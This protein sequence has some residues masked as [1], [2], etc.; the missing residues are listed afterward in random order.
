MQAAISAGDSQMTK[1]HFIELA[2]AISAIMDEHAR[3]QAASAVAGVA[4]QM[5]PRFDT[6]RFFAACGVVQ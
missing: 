5:N 6:Q 2:K 1:K 3:L 4:S